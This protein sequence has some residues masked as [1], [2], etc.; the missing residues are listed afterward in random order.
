[1]QRKYVWWGHAM[2]HRPGWAAQLMLHIYVR[3]G[4]CASCASLPAPTTTTIM[5]A[6][7]QTSIAHT[8]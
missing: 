2:A 8:L 4:V 5:L 7:E 1:M 3:M 6:S